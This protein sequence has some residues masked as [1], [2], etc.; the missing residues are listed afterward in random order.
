MMYLRTVW[1]VLNLLISIILIGPTIIILSLFVKNQRVFTALVRLFAGWTVK[2][3]GMKTEI[4]GL[5]NIDLNRQYVVMGNHESALDIFLVL[6]KIP[7][8]FRIVAKAE[9]RKLPIVGAAMEKAL[10]PFV[11]RK[12][13]RKAVDSMDKTFAEMAKQNLSL[14]IYPEG[15]RGGVGEMIPFKKG[16][17]ILAINNKLPILPMV[18]EGAGKINPPGT[19]WIK[20]T[21]VII[22]FLPVIETSH[23]ALSDRTALRDEVFEKMTAIQKK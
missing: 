21:K 19:M 3:A 17:F 22:N 18:M 8:P 10:F 4:K 14:F 6:A 15:T 2:A 23:L 9:L 20:D 7:L 12:N 16:G 1:V 5:E 11:D 13:H